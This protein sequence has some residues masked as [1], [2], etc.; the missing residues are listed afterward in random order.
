VSCL[1]LIDKN[2]RKNSFNSLRTFILSF[3]KLA[4]SCYN[5]LNKFIKVHKDALSSFSYSNVVYQINCLDCDASYVG[6]TKRTLNTRVSEHRNHA[7]RNS[8]QNLVITDHRS[9]FRHEFDWD[10]IKIL[11]EEI[12]ISA[13]LTTQSLALIRGPQHASL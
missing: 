4:F 1:C 3:S 11:D 9:K 12:V 6:Q 13:F 2:A 7:R 8:I 5:K 10:N